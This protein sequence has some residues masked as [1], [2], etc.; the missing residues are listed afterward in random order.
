MSAKVAGRVGKYDRSATGEYLQAFGRIVINT[1]LY[2][3]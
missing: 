2:W 1:K 3:C